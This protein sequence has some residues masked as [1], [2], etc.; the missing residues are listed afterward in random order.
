M[1]DSITPFLE[2]IKPEVG[3]SADTWGGKLNNDFDVVD[4]AIQSIVEVGNYAAASGADT[5]VVTLDP[6][7]SAYVEGLRVRFKAAADNTTSPTLNV[8]AL[9]AK[10]VKYADGSALAAGGLQAGR[11]YCVDFNGTDFIL[12]DQP[13]ATAAET[14]GAVSTKAMTPASAAAT[15]AV[16][17]YERAIGGVYEKWGTLNVTANISGTSGAASVTFPTAFPTACD[18]VTATIVLPAGTVSGII[19][20]PHVVARSTTAATIGI[21]RAGVGSD[22][23]Y[24]VDWYAKGR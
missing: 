14:A 21:S 5:I 3:A 16:G 1:T 8:N 24:A 10:S 23:P 7:P 19:L 6:A 18:Q 4:A 15:N 9:G 17:V 20:S 11:I 22:G 2:L 12:T 13:K